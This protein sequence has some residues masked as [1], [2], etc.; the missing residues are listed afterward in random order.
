MCSDLCLAE[1]TKLTACFIS[2]WTVN[3]VRVCETDWFMHSSYRVWCM[4]MTTICPLSQPSLSFSFGFS[5]FS[6]FSLLNF[7]LF[8]YFALMRFLRWWPESDKS[9]GAIH[10]LYPPSGVYNSNKFYKKWKPKLKTELKENAEKFVVSFFGSEKI[11]FFCLYFC[12]K[13]QKKIDRCAEGKFPME[14][15]EAT[16]LIHF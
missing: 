13:L 3:A 9:L 10:P 8:Y 6:L 16:H 5:S 4:F 15:W 1:E 7:S 11:R 14:W 12:I 2:L